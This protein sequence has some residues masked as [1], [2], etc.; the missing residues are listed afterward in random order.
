MNGID[1][2]AH[3]HTP[4]ENNALGRAKVG[5]VSTNFGA[6]FHFALYKGPPPPFRTIRGVVSVNFWDFSVVL[7]WGRGGG[8]SGICLSDFRIEDRGTRRRQTRTCFGCMGPQI[9]SF[10]TALCR[11]CIL[12]FDS[13][14]HRSVQAS[15]TRAQKCFRFHTNGLGGRSFLKNVGKGFPLKATTCAPIVINIWD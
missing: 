8:G 5:A 7:E 14:C 12:S 13:H 10:R 4:C 1:T 3:A 9:L 15:H 2:L 11:G 6:V